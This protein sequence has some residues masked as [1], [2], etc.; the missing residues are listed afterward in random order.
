M[1]ELERLRELLSSVEGATFTRHVHASADYKQ[2]GR[3][4]DCTADVRAL[5]EQAE[6]FER[7]YNVTCDLYR[8]AEGAAQAR[9]AELEA[10][11]DH[12]QREPVEMRERI[13]RL[14]H[15]L[16]LRAM[17]VAVLEDE[18]KKLRGQLDNARL[19][20]AANMKQMTMLRAE[21]PE[22]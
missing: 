10:L 17:R 9:I 6:M 18:N 13:A 16:T 19:A 11:R 14:E 2:V 5:L 15:E 7:R 21:E 4:D 20:E 12:L 1:T 22:S 8:Q 3:R